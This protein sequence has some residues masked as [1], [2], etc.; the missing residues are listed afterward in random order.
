MVIPATP[1]NYVCGGLGGVCVPQ[2]G[3]TNKLDTL[4]ERM[5]YRVPYRNFLRNHEVILISLGLRILETSKSCQQAGNT[6]AYTS[7]GHR[8]RTLLLERLLCP[9]GAIRRYSAL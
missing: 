7:L 2:E 5:M 3:T 4:G 6:N 1:W 8:L 9:T